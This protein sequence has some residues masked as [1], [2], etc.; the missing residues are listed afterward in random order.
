MAK[1]PEKFCNNILSKVSRSFALTIPLLDDCLHDPVLITYLQDRLLDNFEDELP[2]LSLSR[3][4]YL[5]NRVVELFDPANNN[6]FEEA[7]EIASYAEFFKKK[8]LAE[9]TENCLLLRKFYDT[10]AP[11]VQ[12][13]SHHWLK[14]MNQGMQKYLSAE[15]ETFSDLNEY[16]FYVAGTVGGFLTDTIIFYSREKDFTLSET[17]RINLL[18]NFNEAGL[19]L[20]KVNLIRDIKE[21]LEKRNKH[22]W[23]LKDLGVSEETLRDPSSKDEAMTALKEMIEDLKTHIPALKKYYNAIPQELSGY[24]KFYA[25]NNGLAL[26]TLE[27]MEDNSKIFYGSSPVKTGKLELAKILKNPEKY[28]E[29]K[30][31]AYTG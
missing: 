2:E 12:G 21:D 22:F 27:K 9:L 16:C 20:Q 18:E 1:N 4:K 29:K 11:Q 24:R 28:F 3:R 19:F 5:M 23:P 30:A 17:D 6:P 13:I 8:S 31:K 26:A 15:V 25:V 7:A 10:L 14:E